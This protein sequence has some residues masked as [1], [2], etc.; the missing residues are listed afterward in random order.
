[1]GGCFGKVD[2]I[3]LTNPTQQALAFGWNTTISPL[4]TIMDSGFRGTLRYALVTFAKKESVEL[5]LSTKINHPQPY[6]CPS[7]PHGMNK[8]LSDYKTARPEV[9]KLN[10]MVNMF[11][12]AFDQR[13][14][15]EKKNKISTKRGLSQPDE[16]GWI[17]VSY[18]N[19]RKRRR[20][21]RNYNR[22]NI[23]WAKEPRASKKKRKKEKVVYFYKFEE[24]QKKQEKLALLKRRFQEDKKKLAKM[25]AQRKFK[26]F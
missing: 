24:R 26:P 2:E 11:M 12:Q 18:K 19:K 17:H 21:L 25:K 6:Q 15:E 13:T 9:S 3:L 8:W 4:S 7:A 22:D 1:M 14:D 10:D 5:A 16:E 20:R 23:E